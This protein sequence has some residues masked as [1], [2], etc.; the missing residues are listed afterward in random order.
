MEKSFRFEF[1]RIGVFLWIARYRP[2][3]LSLGDIQDKEV[4]LSMYLE[5]QQ[6]LTSGSSAIVVKSGRHTPLGV[7]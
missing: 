7:K 3:L 6:L 5:I 4:G 2:K 1:I